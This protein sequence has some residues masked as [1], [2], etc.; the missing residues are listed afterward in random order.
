MLLLFMDFQ[1]VLSTILVLHTA[2]LLLKEPTSQQEKCRN[3]CK[4]MKF[5]GFIVFSTILT[6]LA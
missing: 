4:L 5:T 6:Q 2:L 3:G 1:N